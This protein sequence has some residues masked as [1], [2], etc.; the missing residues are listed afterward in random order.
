MKKFVRAIRGL[1]Y[2][3]LAS[4]FISS[5]NLVGGGGGVPSASNPGYASSATGL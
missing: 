3:S 5:C 1:G 4:I 2:L